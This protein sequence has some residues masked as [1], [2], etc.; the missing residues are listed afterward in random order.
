MTIG[1]SY[2][3]EDIASQCAKYGATKLLLSARE[4]A[5]DCAWYH[6]NWPENFETKP[7]LT[8]VE[9]KTVHFADGTSEEVDAIIVC[10]GYRHYYPFMEQSLR[11]QSA[12]LLFPENLYRNI[13]WE[14]NPK[15]MYSETS[16]S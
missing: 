13:F 2:S 3:A 1:S 11:L 10:T 6:Y 16:K 5:P 4:K 9:G 7:I 12:D 8:K 15:C 14:D